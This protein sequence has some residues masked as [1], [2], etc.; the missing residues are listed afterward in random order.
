M[1]SRV[2]GLCE[3]SL[4][5]RTPPIATVENKYEVESIVLNN[6]VAKGMISM[7]SGGG[8]GV[9]NMILSVKLMHSLDHS[10]DQR[11]S[12]ATVVV[13]VYSMIY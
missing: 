6:K 3:H 12:L 5:V 2:R 10:D 11:V 13:T 7:Q 8:V 1:A 9:A 4:Y